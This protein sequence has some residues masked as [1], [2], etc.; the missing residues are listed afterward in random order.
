MLLR[1][2]IFLVIIG[3]AEYYSYIVVRSALRTLPPNGRKAF[4]ILY[5]LLSICTWV[6][7]LMFRQINWAGIPHMVRNLYVAFTIGF[8]IGKVIILV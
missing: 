1:L 4:M 5:V 7:M 8:L 6:G 3:L 2:V